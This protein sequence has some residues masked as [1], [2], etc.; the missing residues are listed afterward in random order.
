MTDIPTY[1]QEPIVQVIIYVFQKQSGCKIILD[2]LPGY[3]LW[4][5]S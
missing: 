4:T 3:S 1:I 2:S 5:P